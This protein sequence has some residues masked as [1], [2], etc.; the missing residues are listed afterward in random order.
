MNAATWARRVV[1]SLVSIL[2]VAGLL[3][4]D[5]TYEDDFSTDKVQSDSYRHSAFW[6]T[7]TVPLPEPY[8]YYVQTHRGRA[9]AFVDYKDQLAELGYYFP[10]GFAQAQRTIKGVLGIN[11]SFPS[12]TEVSQFPP[13]RLL[14]SVSPDGIAWS[15]PTSLET[16]YNEIPVF[17]PGGVCYVLLTGTRVVI[18][19]LT[20]SLYSNSTTLRVPQDFDTIQ[21]AIDAAGAG[22]VIEVAPGT[23]SGPG[24]RDIEF[25]GKDITVRG[26]AGPEHTI[27]DC[28]GLAGG[29]GDGHRGF[30]FH[31]GEG[32]DSVL[33]GLT[34]RGG[35]AFGPDVPS[36]LTRWNPSAGHPIGGG[37]YCEFSSPT[38]INC[39]IEQCEAEFGGGVGLVGAEAMMS[40]C[41]IEGCTA[42]DRGAGLYCLDS[43]LV[44]AGST[45]S[46][47]TGSSTVRGGGAYCAGATT[48]TIF[49]NC[50]ISQNEAG[51]GA[52]LFAEST[53]FLRGRVNV[54][55]CTVA[56]NALSGYS[57]SVGGGIHS[58]GV[59]L[60]VTNSIVWYNDGT[61]VVVRGTAAK[62]PVT[63]S[64]VQR[65]YP[66]TGNI[67]DD[68]LF[69]ATAIPDY[70]LRSSTGRYDP[71]RGGWVYDGA[72]SPCIDSGDPTAP[73]GDEPAPNGNRINMGAYGGTRQASKGSEHF[74][75][76]VDA[77]GG[78]D[79]NNGLSRNRAFKTM[80]KGIDAARD[81]DTVLVWPG[82]YDE[83]ITFMRKAISVQS[84]ADAAVL[85]ASGGYGAS[86]YFAET[87]RSLLA[88]FVITGC[89]GA[90]FCEG[91]SPSL[92]NLTVV[93]NR[94]GIEAYSGSDPNI[95]NCIVWDNTDGD[96]WDCKARYSCLQERYPDKAAGN[97]HVDPL[98]A[99]PERG[100]YHLKSRYGRYVPLED[101][102]VTDDVTSLCIDAGDP[103]EYPRSERMPN[104]ARIN[105]GAYGGTPYASLSSWPPL[106]EAW[107]T[108]WFAVEGAS[109]SLESLFQM[110]L[111]DGSR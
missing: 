32:V 21:N 72:H 10:F 62:D 88:N 76:H 84:A 104:G 61:P 101:T 82:V 98:F 83:E 19:D 23:Y 111:P 91:A 39:I 16:G 44:V 110:E 97:I 18:D 27:I 50:A 75:Y 53:S 81:G 99:D 54:I 1:A 22:D 95:I 77:A 43:A 14:Y 103:E 8:L 86:F 42:T 40:D 74:I 92:K 11:V 13:G 2:L 52:G 93:G 66:G 26:T 87:S 47:N 58:D 33:S 100:D 108:Y 31:E 85:R 46:R 41:T 51:M 7:G 90:V 80:Q 67:D 45:M 68:P 36:D 65:G 63:Y 5:W 4:A 60:L 29:I 109:A 56:Q 25:R 38:I 17:S 73:V 48:D 89:G 94:F 37:I 55:N 78:R 107:M 69:A 12:S 6:S 30:Y 102:W 24:Y 3:K 57:P 96:L 35:R 9:L 105:L 64:N 20:V 79:W 49:R 15:A 70:H 106:D 71:Q 28:G 59:D 34:I